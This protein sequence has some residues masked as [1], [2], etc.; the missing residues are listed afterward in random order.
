MTE[1]N[2]ARRIRTAYTSMR[3]FD[4]RRANRGFRKL[5][6]ERDE[7]IAKLLPRLNK[8]LSACR[9]LDFGCGIGDVTNWFHLHGVSAEQ[10]IGIDLLHDQIVRARETY[11]NL[12]FV[13]ANGEHLPF[14]DGH[15][16]IVI[17]FTVF[18]SILDHAL[19]KRI[20]SEITRVLAADGVVVWRDIRYPNPWNHHTRAMT[21]PL[22]HDLFRTM[23]AELKTVTLMPPIAE[24]LGR[25]TDVLY[26]LLV[27]IP[28][29]RSHYF[30]LLR[31]TRSMPS[32]SNSRE[33]VSS[34]QRH[35][36]ARR[37]VDF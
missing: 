12:T 5:T 11:P 18:S 24:R 37:H 35:H 21:K 20:A 19:S 14:P 7:A 2:E 25:L 16:D 6:K 23:K 28:P 8:P 27:S 15:F 34:T 29:L 13:E 33:N 9:V 4:E 3:T 10:I 1:D 32:R 31:A 30:G 17:T 36:A 22:I 26:P